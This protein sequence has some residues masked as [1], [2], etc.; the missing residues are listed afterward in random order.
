MCQYNLKLSS[1]YAPPIISIETTH[2]LSRFR[3][4]PDFCQ[5]GT[6][7]YQGS[8]S[9]I[10]TGRRPDDFKLCN[11]A[12]H[13]ATTPTGYTWHH[14]YMVPRTEDYICEMHSLKRHIIV[15]PVA[16]LEDSASMSATMMPGS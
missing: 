13:Y 16:T 12:A 14:K 3:Y 2:S 6:P 4:S 7:D 5:C 1:P 10:M 15:K 11:R 8:V 9:I